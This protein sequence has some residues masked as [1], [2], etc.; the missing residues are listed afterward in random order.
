MA[1]MGQWLE[2]V[3]VN[4]SL[5]IRQSQAESIAQDSETVR[6]R[7]W[8]EILA[9]RVCGRSGAPIFPTQTTSDGYRAM[10]P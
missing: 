3:L 2:R 1:H 8:Q 7:L 9:K 4:P 10:A 5:S 6:P